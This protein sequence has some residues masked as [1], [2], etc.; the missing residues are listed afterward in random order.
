MNLQHIAMKKDLDY[1]EQRIQDYVPMQKFLELKDLS[2][3][4][5]HQ[6]E[7]TRVEAM[8]RENI[9]SQGKYA[10]K[11]EIIEKFNRM[12]KEMWDE[13]KLKMEKRT[14]TQKFEFVEDEIEKLAERNVKEIAQVREVCDRMR[15]K[16]E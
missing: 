15:K 13:L 4:F 11:V 1:I 9:N 3:E 7:V 10:V 8:L 16:N 12:E 14:V 2:M 5:A 6:S